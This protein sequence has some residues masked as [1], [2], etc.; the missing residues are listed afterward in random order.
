MSRS[1]NRWRMHKLGF[2]NFWL[3]DREE[4]IL[5]SGHLLLRGDNAS[6]KSIT[7]QSF[8]PFLL[9]GNKSP[10]RLDPFGSRDRKMD[11][12]LLGDGEH[13]ESTGYL[14]LEFKKEGLDEYSTIGVGMRAQKGKNI[15]FWGFCLCDG[16]RIQKG[17]VELYETLGKQL[18]PLSKQ[19]L[20]N[21]I[22]DENNWAE[23][24]SIYKQLVNDRIFRFRDVRQYEQLIQL[25]IKVRTP[26]LSK[27]A[28]RPTAV[29]AVLKDS[30]R[31]L[32]DEDLSA[33]VSTMERMDV[34][35]DTLRDYQ[36]AMRDAM[37][38]RNEYTRYNQYML[39]KKG[40]AY[41]E[42][43][44][45]TVRL[46]NQVNTEQETLTAQEAE[47]T[48]C[49]Q[50]KE[51]A[52]SRLAQAKAQKEALGE[53]D[54]TIQQER[55]KREEEDLRRYQEQLDEGTARVQKLQEQ[56]YSREVKLR[57]LTRAVEDMRAALRSALRGLE[58][59]NAI[60]ELGPEHTDYSSRL[61]SEQ[62]TDF[63]CVHTA[64]QRRK[65]QISETLST[66]RKLEQANEAYDAACQ[67]LD[68]AR[69]GE[70]AARVTLRDAETQ[71]R[72][73]RD[74]LIEGIAH[75][76]ILNEE[77]LFSEG[78]LLALR[79]AIARYASPADWSAIR[80]KIDGC[81]YQKRTAL[82]TAKLGLQSELNAL[83]K[84]CDALRR[85]QNQLLN[86]PDPVP[87]RNSQIEATR[88]QL[89]MQGIPHA[90]FYE[91]V[92]FSPDL[93]QEARN[94]LEAQLSD[95]GLLDALIVP[96]TALVQIQG[97]LRQYPDRFLL[98]GP[99]SDDPI[100]GLQPDGDSHYQEM[101]AACLS[102]ISQ[103]D[104]NAHTALLP[105]GRFK[106][107]MINGHSQ[108]EK[109]A[110]FVGA[111][112]RR[113]NRERQ[114][115][116]LEQQLAEMQAKLDE[117]HAATVELERRLN[118][119]R[120]EREHMPTAIDLDQS[121]EMLS[122]AR[123]ALVDAEA[124]V[125]KCSS[126][127][128]TAKRFAAQLDQEC[129]TL[130]RGL[131]YERASAAYE[132]ALDAA[133]EY[134][135]QLTALS[136]TAMKL[137]YSRQSLLALE[138]SIAEQRDQADALQKTNRGTKSQIE[139]ADAAIQEIQAVLDA[140]EN[141]ERAKRLAELSDEIERQQERE[142]SADKR[143]AVLSS[144]IQSSRDQL[145]LRR[146]AFTQ[147]VMD[148][149]DYETY[150]SEDL[151]LGLLPL[152]REA[153][154]AACAREAQS[155][156]QASDRE[157]TQMQI[158]DSLRNNY[159]QHNNSLLRYQPKIEPVFEPPSR[160]T[161]LRQRLCIT[162][163]RDGKEL[164]LQEFIARLQMDVD[165][166]TTL[167]EEKDRELF[168]DILTETISHKL[169][170]RINESQQWAQAMTALM[171]T[172]KTSMG[173]VFSL[174]WKAKKA[175][176]AAE[177]DTAQLVQLLSKDRALLTP[178]DSKRVSTHFRTK[179]KKARQNA[180]EQE[181]QTNYADLIR[182]VLDYRDWYEF[183]LFYQRDSEGKKELTDRVFNKF[184]GG[185]KA[186]AMYVPLFAA[187]SAQYQ[188]GGESCP[189]LLALDEAFAGVDDR[190]I[191]AMFELVHVLDFDYIMN[192]Q[193]LWGCYAGVKSL[194][195]AELHRPSNAQVVTI[196]RYHWDGTER[197]LMENAT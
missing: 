113:A 110:G 37:I 87:L 122:S 13:E 190:N 4:F 154:L 148:E 54:L 182:E 194:D 86:N 184:S 95:A 24:P 11:Y 179:V 85:T 92:D 135:V 193:A 76:Q 166:T 164:S 7:T 150:F 157:R 130:S 98:P 100:A 141:R 67:A 15:D 20:K 102:S 143:T 196:L 12:Y 35:E 23:S 103:S 8:I 137:D 71:E 168:E 116:A 70:S 40:Q 77:L 9:D 105:D 197:V 163:Q 129:R 178:E 126:A 39:G 57:E 44:E 115:Q 62:N 10:E 60:L 112:A 117:R 188:K 45:K 108:A 124:A 58:A 173:L 68:E 136:Q 36:T 156:I 187:V 131:P 185:E 31:V 151:S 18:L 53:D 84:E 27:E 48:A 140:P 127:E 189:M 64:L 69:T 74:R 161:M 49:V 104:L 158:E 47:I 19:K 172:L 81:T 65:K 146:Q 159:Q 25:L 82:E 41:L 149:Q 50:V 106:C 1:M 152:D 128:Q 132:E 174:D 176:E 195:I 192:S 66:L 46:S 72:E 16:R 121:L 138:D 52:A 59:Q 181:L 111:A 162:L 144:Q 78:E 145:Q 91:T 32:T 191:S 133:E 75:R 183:L 123:K 175:E 101:A 109:P 2:L 165:M 142:H 5:D 114:L 73:E 160:E 56:I 90:A 28:F 89:T 170:A 125:Q 180:A 34:L 30:L 169:S 99:P 61:K 29:K 153:G 186:M 43:L 38:I 55:L 97:L 79:Q 51:E 22:N 63:E 3:Y 33:M 119:L 21:L 93:S 88:I 147:A 167:L 83:Q 177:L 17:G 171:G 14:Y 80:E 94:L 139:R 134:L 118:L 107:G 26:K 155:K 42:A 96:E 6:G 120:E